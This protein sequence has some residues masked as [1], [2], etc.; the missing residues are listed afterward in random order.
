MLVIAGIKVHSHSRLS[1]LYVI[2]FKKSWS[3]G[4]IWRGGEKGRSQFCSISRLRAQSCYDEC[5]IFILQLVSERFL[6]FDPE[7]MFLFYQGTERKKINCLKTK[8]GTNSITF[9]YSLQ[10]LYCHSR[11]QNIRPVIVKEEMQAK[12]YVIP[13]ECSYLIA[14]IS[15]NNVVVPNGAVA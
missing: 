2:V 7:L 14:L 3:Y 15:N 10:A 4:A 11:M 9:I 1:I 13:R 12:G 5:D 6:C 8:D